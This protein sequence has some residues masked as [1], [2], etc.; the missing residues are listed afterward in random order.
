MISSRTTLL[1]AA[2]LAA[3]VLAAGRPSAEPSDCQAGKP[4]PLTRPTFKVD[5]NWPQEMPNHWIMGA[6]T[7]VFVDSKQHVWVDAPARD[8]D[9][10]R[11]LR[12]AVEG[13]NGRRAWQTE[14]GA[15]RHLLQGRAA[16][17]GIR[18]ARQAGSGLGPGLVYRLRPT[19]RASRTASSSITRTTSGSAATTG[20]A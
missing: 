4:S 18:S 11:A 3:I 5:P 10:R 9:R 13:R 6:V 1:C 2:L 8:A 19:G 17:P 14:A 15:D 7:G 20:I 12:G 16:D